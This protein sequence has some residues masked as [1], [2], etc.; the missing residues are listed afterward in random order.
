M[1]CSRLSDVPSAEQTVDKKSLFWRCGYTPGGTGMKRHSHGGKGG[2]DTPAAVTESK[3]GSAHDC[4]GSFEHFDHRQMPLPFAIRDHEVE[5]AGIVFAGSDC[6]ARIRM[7]WSGRPVVSRRRA[8]G[9]FVI[10][11]L[12]CR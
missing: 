4:S 3:D 9:G 12:R 11:C 8:S 10:C 2:R 6:R 7:T 1:T 5:F